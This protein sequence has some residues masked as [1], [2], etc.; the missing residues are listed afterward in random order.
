[1]QLV[2]VSEKNE[3]RGELQ[4]TSNGEHP[5]TGIPKMLDTGA[6]IAKI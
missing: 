6:S 5:N 4:F 1:L 3:Q 2:N